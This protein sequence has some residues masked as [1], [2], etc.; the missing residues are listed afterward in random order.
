[1]IEALLKNIKAG[2]PR[3]IAKAITLIESNLTEDRKPAMELL[4]K[5]QAGRKSNTIRIGI[6]GIPGVGKS[7]FID[8]LGSHVL[9]S[10]PTTKIA[11]LTI[12]PS[13]P[14]EGG[15][16]LADRLRMTELSKHPNVFIR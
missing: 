10:H 5:L 11:I 1:M 8:K 16:I 4:S 14:M 9:A 12:D 7:T 6:S 3:A 13:S 2:D 15:S